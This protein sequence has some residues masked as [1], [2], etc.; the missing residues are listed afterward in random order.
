MEREELLRI[1]D[2]KVNDIFLA[3]QEAEDIESGDITPDEE[4]RLDA[5]IE[6]LC[7]C[8]IESMEKNLPY[9]EKKIAP[10]MLSR[11]GWTV[12]DGC[13]PSLRD[14]NLRDSDRLIVIESPGTANDGTDYHAEVLV[15]VGYWGEHDL[16][17]KFH[18]DVSID[19][20]YADF[21]Y[22]DDYFFDFEYLHGDF[23]KF[24]KLED[25]LST[26]WVKEFDRMVDYTNEHMDRA[27]ELM[28]EEIKKSSKFPEL[29]GI[30]KD[31]SERGRAGYDHRPDLV[32]EPEEAERE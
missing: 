29:Y 12:T 25:I 21:Y 6:N 30:I 32:K 24:E 11:A 26:V 1:I 10:V 9:P 13:F 3:Y 22:D 15:K 2:D 31:M 19:R 16:L 8:V 7:D 27:D 23:E 4:M 14:S 18:L 17:R 28:M 20:D 5:I